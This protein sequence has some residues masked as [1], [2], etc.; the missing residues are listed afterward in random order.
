[1]NSSIF[2]I[3]LL[4]VVFLSLFC[5]SY[6]T[7]GQ[8]YIESLHTILIY[9]YY[10]VILI[11]ALLLITFQ[12]IKIFKD[13]QFQIIRLESR[14]QC[15]QIAIKQIIYNCSICFAINLLCLLIGCNLF[16]SYYFEIKTLNYGITNLTYVV[17]LAIRSY[18]YI[19]MIMIINALFLYIIDLKVLTIIDAI[20]IITIPIYNYYLPTFSIGKTD[21]PFLIS[22]FFNPL[23]F[24]NFSI[25]LCVSC[26][27][28]LL[29][30]IF[31]YFLFYF[32]LKHNKQM[33]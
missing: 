24:D 14:K 23:K 2:K 5:T 12:T 17:F 19:I 8:T 10:Y 15:F 16:H 6:I 11:T 3:Y 25:E 18:L 31:C 32:V 29:V 7:N 4:M 30:L 21:I 13:N 33:I 20:M 27:Y 9:P 26:G 22:G 28:F 1:M